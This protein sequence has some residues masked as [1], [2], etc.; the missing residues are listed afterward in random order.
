M[1]D[2][3]EP[4]LLPNLTN[5]LCLW[6]DY[7]FLSLRRRLRV[8]VRARAQSV[9]ACVHGTV[10]VLLRT[11]YGSS[12]KAAAILATFAAALLYHRHE[13]LLKTLQVLRRKVC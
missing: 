1:Q 4:Q 11:V 3:A 7:V 8:C 13:K 9:R 5:R 10:S 12:G 2:A 6:V